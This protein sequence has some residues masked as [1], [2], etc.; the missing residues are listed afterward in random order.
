MP[1]H[2]FKTTSESRPVLP[3]DPRTYIMQLT[4]LFAFV[5]SLAAL[6]QVVAAPTPEPQFDWPGGPVTYCWLGQQQCPPGKYCRPTRFPLPNDGEHIA[7][8][9]QSTPFPTKVS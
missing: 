5:A 9:C 4:L 2:S 6:D 3:T 8:T 1:C 7:P